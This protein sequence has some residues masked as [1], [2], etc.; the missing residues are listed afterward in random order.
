[1][2]D[3]FNFNPHKWIL[4]NF[5][6]SALWYLSNRDY[7]HSSK[8]VTI[9]YILRFKDSKNIVDALYVDNYYLNNN[10]Q[11][12]SSAPDYRVFTRYTEIS[13]YRTYLSLIRKYWLHLSALAS[14]TW[15][16]ISSSQNVVCYA[17]VWSR[18][19]AGA[20]SQP[21]AISKSFPPA[22]GGWCSIRVPCASFH[23]PCLFSSQG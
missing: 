8:I 7:K 5:D 23:G 20:R 12:P 9:F 15:E 13:V 2:A 18:R 1:M 4:I 21:S 22:D 3:S 19:S 14:C 6:C 16:T 10:E 17:L 11:R